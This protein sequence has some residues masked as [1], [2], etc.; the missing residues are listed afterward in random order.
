MNSIPLLGIQNCIYSL[1]DGHLGCVHFLAMVNN[2][3]MNICMQVFTWTYIF[4]SLGHT[5]RSGI[6]ESY[7]HSVFTILKNCQPFL[8]HIFFA[9]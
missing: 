4:S 2:A 8:M 9:A 5:H 3:S 7:G 1:V 6:A